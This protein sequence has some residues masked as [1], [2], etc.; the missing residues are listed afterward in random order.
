M[1]RLIR[2]LLGLVLLVA[3][4]YVAVTVRLGER[5]LWQHLCAIA[6]SHESRALVEGVRRRAR[7]LWGQAGAEGAS[8]ATSAPAPTKAVD[9]L[10]ADE[11]SRLRQ[12]I[13]QRLAAHP[14]SAPDARL[15]AQPSSNSLQKTT[16][17]RRSSVAP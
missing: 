6:G 3:L 5:T 13:R 4:V 1:F 2:G 11:R 17:T 15:G 16:S 10:T 9:P 12:L 14:A 7:A 8:G